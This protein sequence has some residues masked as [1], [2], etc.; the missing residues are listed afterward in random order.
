[1]ITKLLV[2]ADTVASSNKPVVGDILIDRQGAH[3]I[4]F[5]DATRVVISDPELYR[6][7]ERRLDKPSIFLISN[8]SR[9]DAAQAKHSPAAPVWGAKG[10]SF[11]F[12]IQVKPKSGHPI[13]LGTLARS[14]GHARN[15]VLFTL[16]RNMN[17]TLLPKFCVSNA[18]RYVSD[19]TGLPF[20]PNLL[21][22]FVIRQI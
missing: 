2:L 17:A 22:P 12:E 13:V 10:A 6:D 14:V 4:K 16:G 5:V 15:N 7:E 18:K 21:V 3:T 19:V 8:L 1:M 11:S 20:S 9:I